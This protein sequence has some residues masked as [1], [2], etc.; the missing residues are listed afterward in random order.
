MA[1]INQG[2]SVFGHLNKG[3]NSLH[4]NDALVL[5]GALDANVED[6]VEVD[7]R[8]ARIVR[9]HRMRRFAA[10]KKVRD[11]AWNARMAAFRLPLTRH[12]GEALVGLL[13][14]KERLHVVLPRTRDVDLSSATLVDELASCLAMAETTA[15]S[16]NLFTAAKIIDEYLDEMST[17]RTW[18]LLAARYVERLM[19]DE[20]DLDLY[21]EPDVCPRKVLVV[22]LS[23]Q[24]AEPDHTVDRT[25]EARQESNNERWCDEDHD[26]GMGDL[27]AWAGEFW[28]DLPGSGP[29]RTVR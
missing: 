18:N 26:A 1:M 2:P 7:Y 5:A 16:G 28:K 12:D 22:K 24:E 25:G 6:L 8:V 10:W 3:R 11:E 27:V 29:G 4:I 20:D 17:Q 14:G 15:R 9:E 23:R 19:F 13:L 21:G